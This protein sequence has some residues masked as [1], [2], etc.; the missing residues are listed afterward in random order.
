GRLGEPEGDAARRRR[1]PVDVPLVVR[2]VDAVELARAGA[3]LGV[4]LLRDPDAFAAGAARGEERSEDEGQGKTKTH[5]TSRAGTEDREEGGA[6]NRRRA[7]SRNLPRA[8]RARMPRGVRRSGA[9][10]VL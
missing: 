9:A 1:D 7:P 2:D 10:G 4:R 8:R 5:G 3:D 6:G